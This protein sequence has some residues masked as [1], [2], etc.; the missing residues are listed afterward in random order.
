MK[1]SLSYFLLSLVVITFSFASCRKNTTKPEPEPEPVNEPE[2]ITTMK[3]YIQDSITGLPVEGSPFT[4][5]DA[6]GDGGQPG[7]FLN[8]G[9][10]SLIQLLSN[11]V[12]QCR[13]YLL[14]ESKSPVDTIS[15][16]IAGEEGYEHMVFYNEGQALIANG[17]TVLKAGYPNYT[18]K[19]NGPNISI[20]Y[21]DSDNGPAHGAATGNIGLITMFRTNAPT[22]KNW[23]LIITLRH[24]PGSKG[25]NFSAGETDIEVTYKVKV[26]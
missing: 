2:L 3:V 1:R 14:D 13:I 12:Y 26:N 17:N 24:Q 18:V 21:L 25:Y 8:N 7:A 23:P 10:D 5:K 19:L 15:N 20:R 4:F 16:A 6:D 22:S 9:K 11:R